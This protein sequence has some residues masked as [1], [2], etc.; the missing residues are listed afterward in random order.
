MGESIHHEEWLRSSSQISWW[1]RGD[2]MYCLVFW[3]YTSAKFE[4]SAFLYR[5][6]IARYMLSLCVRLCGV[7]VAYQQLS[8]WTRLQ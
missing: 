6:M 7:D 1:Y 3:L 8:D 4:F 5:A 2:R